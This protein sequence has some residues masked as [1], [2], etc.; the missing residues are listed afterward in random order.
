MSFLRVSIRSQRLGWEIPVVEETIS[1]PE[2]FNPLPAVGLGDTGV[3][4]RWKRSKKFQS[5]PSGWAGRYAIQVAPQKAVKCFNPLPAVG[6]GDT[7]MTRFYPSYLHLFQS[8][9]SGWAGRYRM[10]N[11]QSV[12]L[13][14]FNPLPAVGLGDTDK[15]SMALVAFNVSI[16]SQRLGWEIPSSS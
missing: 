16:R 9:P 10:I 8:A 14:S 5:A 12:Y 4:S 15:D 2:G 3:L 7:L 6:L 11:K 13:L 1:I